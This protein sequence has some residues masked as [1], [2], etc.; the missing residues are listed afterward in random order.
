MFSPQI[1]LISM[2]SL[3][4][5]SRCPLAYMFILKIIV[6]FLIIKLVF[7]NT[8]SFYTNGIKIIVSHLLKQV[9]KYILN[10]KSYSF[11]IQTSGTDHNHLNLKIQ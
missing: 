10:R 6:I 4:V 8:K 11:N 2:I 5:V 3:S 1:P 9:I 7:I